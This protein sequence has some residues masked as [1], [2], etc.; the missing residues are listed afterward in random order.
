MATAV[1][2]LYSCAAA[3]T[4]TMMGDQRDFMYIH[5]VYMHV[6]DMC[7]MYIYMHFITL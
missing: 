5:M 1:V 2:P 6:Y 7:M 3:A 4:D